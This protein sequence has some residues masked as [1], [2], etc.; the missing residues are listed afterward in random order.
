MPKPSGLPTNVT[1]FKDRHGKWRLRFRARGKPTHYFAA[2]IGS[3]A[4]RIELDA[5]RNSGEVAQARHTQRVPPGSIAALVALYRT[6]SAYTG[7]EPAS[8]KTYNATLRR[9]VEAHGSKSVATIERKHIKAI[10]GGMSGTPQAANK[11]LSKLRILMALALDEGWRKDDP[12]QGIKGYNRKT[13]G[14]HTWSEAE[15]ATYEAR[16][17]LG[18]KARLASDILLYTGQRKSDGVR[19]G[20]QHLSADG[21]ISVAQQKTKKRLSIP[22]HAR[23][24]ASIAAAAASGVLGEL[25]LL[26]TEYGKPFTAAGFGDRMRKWCDE[27]GLPQCTAHGLRKAAARRLAEAGCTHEQIKAITGHVTDAEVS[28]YVAAANQLRLADQAMEKIAEG[29]KGERQIG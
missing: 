29:P 16:H 1:E 14:H 3:E 28:R 17:P 11:L 6:T 5:C 24:R 13:E 22:V 2:P 19:A 7:L 26:V 20:R 27:A 9:F 18:T 25:T 8:R 12:T 23:L 15:I 4:F 21:R 10:I